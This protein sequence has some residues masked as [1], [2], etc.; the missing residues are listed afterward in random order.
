MGHCRGNPGLQ[1]SARLD[2]E[3]ARTLL[4]ITSLPADE[5]ISRSLSSPVGLHVSD[6]LPR[7]WYESPS[8][9][10]DNVPRRTER[11]ILALL[12][13]GQLHKVAEKDIPYNFEHHR[14]RNWWRFGRFDPPPLLAR[15]D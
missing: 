5:N 2:C 10:I 9:L 1:Q 3:L 6:F 13:L 8:V 14:I 15:R 4:L 11:H 7:E 12:E